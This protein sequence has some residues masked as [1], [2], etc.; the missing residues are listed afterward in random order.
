LLNS[1]EY[2]GSLSWSPNE[3]HVAFVGEIK[4]KDGDFFF[5]L[6][7][8]SLAKKL[9]IQSIQLEKNK[10]KTGSSS[11]VKTLLWILLSNFL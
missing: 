9:K 1:I 10:G 2:F 8:F 11:S 5:L 4:E 7:H 6:F 3:T